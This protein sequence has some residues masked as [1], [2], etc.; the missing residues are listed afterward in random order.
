L[1]ASEYAQQA[2]GTDTSGPVIDLKPLSQED[3]LVLLGNITNVEVLGDK[4][5]WLLNND[6]M[7]KFLERLY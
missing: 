4:D 5:K 1:V 2:G 7:T 3:L 6:Q